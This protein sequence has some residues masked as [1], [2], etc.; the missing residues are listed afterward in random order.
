MTAKLTQ[1]S[2]RGLK[3]YQAAHNTRSDAERDA[4][5]CKHLPLVHSVVERIL[6]TLPNS[7]DR[8]DLFHVGVLG[9]IDAVDRYDPSRQTAFSTYAV[10][11]IRGAIIDDLR[12]RDT[13]SRGMRSRTKEYHQAIHDLTN[14]LGRLPED[15][16]LSAHLGVGEQD[17]LEIERHAQLSIQVS[18]DAPIGD[19]S[20]LADLLGCHRMNDVDDNMQ[21]E[22]QHRVLLDAIDKLKEHERL[23][24][25]LYYFEQLLMKEIALI[26]D[27]TESRVCQIHSRV[28]AMLRKR[29]L[30]TGVD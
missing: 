8:D 9:L 28:V 2:H 1:Q 25:K 10:L 21:K 20:T 12:S 30:G 29:L 5:I 15:A 26:L 11:R 23:V 3:A 4:E 22:D 19:R 24:I 27:I 13:I 16:E 18:L 6:P 14:E 17:L 7:V